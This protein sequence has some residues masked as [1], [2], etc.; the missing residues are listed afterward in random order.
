MRFNLSN[1][2]RWILGVIVGIVVI[3]VAL[4]LLM[5]GEKTRT[6]VE[7]QMNSRLKGY[8]VHVG[9]A[10]FSPIT[11]SL[12]LSNVTLIQN[13]NP[14]LP[15]ARIAGL[16]AH[17]HWGDLLRGH[18]VG[19]LSIDS[20][21]VF[22]NLAHFRT[23][24][25]S[26]VP[27]KN[28]GWQEAVQSIYPI[29]INEFRISNGDLTYKDQGP[30]RP[31]HATRIELRASNI[32]NIKYPKDALPSAVAFQA[33]VFD[34]GRLR[35]QG[36]A[37][38]LREPHMAF[39]GNIELANLDLSYFE[40]I[41]AR[42]N[43]SVS[44][45]TLSAGGEVEY[46]PDVTAI[47]ARKVEIDGVN[48][49]YVHLPQ[50]AA[51]EKR[52]IRETSQQAGQLSNEPAAQVRVNDLAIRNSTFAYTDKTSKPPYRVFFS[53]ISGDVL[54]FS[55]QLREGPSTVDM[56]GKFMGSGQTR[57]TGDSRPETK[58]A[59]LDLRIAIENT[60]MTAMNDLF[61]SA[62]KF[63]IKQGDFSFY[64]QMRIQNGYLNG[65]VKPLFKDVKIADTSGNQKKGVL[66]KACVEGAKV[67]A[68]VLQNPPRK[69]IA[70]TTD[71]SGPIENPNTSMWQIV[72]H[73]I[74]NAW[75]RAILPGFASQAQL[76]NQ[77]K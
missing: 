30:F 70:T 14:D 3:I 22:I 73:T 55:N 74:Q 40:P 1:K 75:V 5:C 71:I 34:K 11:F 68:K 59:N 27:L 60:S 25:K 51:V 49:N 54:K 28:K 66:H 53:D 46:S 18:V 12:R 23:E 45:G 8:T 50:T 72:T 56:R 2:W 67:L 33:D 65:W 24:E 63:E 58:Q 47:N 44:R 41:L 21:K 52:R 26:K 64:A 16:N 19:E 31:L 6:Y 77:G 9:K 10:C 17:L 42:Q 20:P 39:Q 36:R 62:G 37:N 7:H 76:E 4:S 29:D 69:Q 48:A 57:I 15:V 13:A 35:M 61:R 43:I 32:R 38:F